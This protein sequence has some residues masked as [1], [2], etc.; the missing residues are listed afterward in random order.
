MSNGWPS[1]AGAAGEKGLCEAVLAGACERGANCSLS[2][3]GVARGDMEHGD[4]AVK[5]PWAYAGLYLGH[6]Q[7]RWGIFRL[8]LRLRPRL[9]A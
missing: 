3:A 2:I 9:R 5:L 6:G 1:T 8:P 4:R 7:A